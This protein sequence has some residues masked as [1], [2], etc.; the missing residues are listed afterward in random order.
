MINSVKSFAS[1]HAIFDKYDVEGPREDIQ[2]VLPALF[3]PETI[4]EDLVAIEPYPE[5]CEIG[6]NWITKKLEED[7]SLFRKTQGFRYSPSLNYIFDRPFFNT[8]IDSVKTIASLHAIFDKYDIKG[9]KEDINL[10][11]PTLFKP[12]TIAEDLV[13]IEPY[14]ELCEIGINW[15][16]ENWKKVK[17]RED[18]LALMETG[19]HLQTL[20]KIMTLI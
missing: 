4:A 13:A 20:L 12:E 15:I 8:V 19:D 6:I 16:T 9:L 14:P 18:W 3:K 11:L 10:V 1:L 2:Q 5:L 7:V 17:G